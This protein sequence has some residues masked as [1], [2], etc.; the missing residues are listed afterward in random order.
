M[1]RSV[2]SK[3]KLNIYSLLGIFSPVFV[4]LTM[5]FFIG[6]LLKKWEICGKR[7]FNYKHYLLSDFLK[8]K[9]QK[10]QFMMNI[11][12]PL[13]ALL[14]CNSNQNA[15]SFGN[16]RKLVRKNVRSLSITTVTCTN[17][18]V[19]RDS[20]TNDWSGWVEGSCPVPSRKES[21]DTC[22]LE[23]TLNWQQSSECAFGTAGMKDSGIACYQKLTMAS[24]SLMV[25][26]D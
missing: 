18:L 23:W 6:T 22:V 1:G 25:T 7:N 19:T 12:M 17:S 2:K 21:S 14:I 4:M 8:R 15:V 13:A 16:L 26:W 3:V 24:M 5:K 9:S 20:N 11:F 10:H